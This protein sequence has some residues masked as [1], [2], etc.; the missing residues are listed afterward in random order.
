MH[1]IYVTVSE[2]NYGELRVHVC[3]FDVALQKRIDR[4]GKIGAAAK[5]GC[6]ACVEIL[7]KSRRAVKRR[8]IP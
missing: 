4:G 8:E 7:A 3:D 5:A 6:S 1:R 2:S